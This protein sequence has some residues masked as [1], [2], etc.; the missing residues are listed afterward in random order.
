MKVTKAQL[1]TALR[2][3]AD[4]LIEG[5]P[6]TRKP[7]VGLKEINRMFGLAGNTSY[8]WRSRGVLPKED[9]ELSNNPVWKVPTIYRFAD[10]TNRTIIWDP[11]G[12][13]ENAD[14]DDL[15]G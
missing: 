15:Q 14:P 11:W 9:G 5:G 10:E 2:P 13:Q 12:I 3:V 4:D 1:R 7:V 6:M 8:Q